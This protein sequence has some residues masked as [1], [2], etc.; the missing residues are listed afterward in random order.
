MRAAKIGL[1]FVILLF[2]ATVETAWQ[3]RENIGIG[4]MGCQ[5]LG[6]RLYGSSFSFESSESAPVTPG[7]A[8]A[9][10]NAFGSVTVRAGGPGEAKV[11]LRKVVYRPNEQEARAF[12]ERIRVVLREESGRLVL[13]TN[14]EELDRER[15]GGRQV[16]FETHLEVTVPA[17]TP[18]SV[19]NEHGTIDASGVAQADLAGS[20]DDVKAERIAGALKLDVR[21]GDAEV[22]QVGGTL[23]LTG[24]HG[25]VEAEDVTGTVTIGVEHGNVKLARLGPATVSTT[26]GD[27][28]VDGVAGDLEVRVEH[29]GV[30]AEHVAGRVSA[31]SS[32][33]SVT[34]RHVDGEARLHADHGGVEAEDVL[35]ALTA[36]AS[37]AGV[38][39]T[40]IG[41]DVDVT[42]DHGGLEGRDLA[43][44]V[45]VKSSGDDVRITGFAAA[46]DVRSDRG[47]VELEPSGP[48]RYPVVVHAQHGGITLS[49]P[50][51]SDVSLEASAEPGDL[52]VD[53][54]GWSAERSDRS[55]AA[56]RIGNGGVP[57][58][59]TASNGD[60]A[61]RQGVASGD[62]ARDERD[63]A[64]SSAPPSTEP[65]A[66][67]STPKA[68]KAPRASAAPKAPTAPTASASP[69]AN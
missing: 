50:A 5:V 36:E 52:D 48:I 53:L 23:A 61:V 59:L 20:F 58:K 44:T 21:H 38:E 55:S 28:T 69:S 25:D 10:Q 11:V 3:V 39:L 7:R 8:V 41:K 43:G 24:R 47:S 14:R 35:G 15:P 45:R 65:P 6:G 68:P 30:Q 62:E 31:T 34:V 22:R 42:V 40:R 4:P 66:P 12:A 27:V 56:G 17:D 9:V 32:Y 67:P 49:V 2:G 60:V 13:T 1:L 26:H 37:F 19:Q 18:L 16:G 54:P 64:A 29:G 51:G 33:D 46:V 57:V 63:P